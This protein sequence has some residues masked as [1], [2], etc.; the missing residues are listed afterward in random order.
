[1]TTLTPE[2]IATLRQLSPDD[3]DRAID[4]LT[5]DD[6]PPDTRTPEEWAKEIARRIEDV[7]SGRVKLL[8]RHEADQQVR[9]ALR[10]RGF[11]L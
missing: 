9:E 3:K 2:L 10:A 6:G 1:M 7:N 5:E 11:E 8:D 4:V